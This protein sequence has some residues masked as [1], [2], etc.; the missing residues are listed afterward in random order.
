MYNRGDLGVGFIPVTTTPR[1]TK[2]LHRCRRPRVIFFSSVSYMSGNMVCM[3]F[4]VHGSS[5]I[6]YDDDGGPSGCI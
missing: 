2:P 1:P 5:Q 3:Y 6:F 4:F